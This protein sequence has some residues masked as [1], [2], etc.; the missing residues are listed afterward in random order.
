M[1]HLSWPLAKE[2]W[3]KNWMKGDKYLFGACTQ[4][5]VEQSLGDLKANVGDVR[6][7]VDQS[8]E[9]HARLGSEIFLEPGTHVSL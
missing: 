4:I 7:V 5:C 9:V 6:K 3:P 1:S 8:S 2:G